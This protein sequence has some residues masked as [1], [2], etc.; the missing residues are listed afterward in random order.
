MPQLTHQTALFEAPFWAFRA[1]GAVACTVALPSRSPSAFPQML[2][3]DAGMVCWEEACSGRL[4]SKG[5]LCWLTGP[6]ARRGGGLTGK[7]LPGFAPPG[8]P[9]CRS[10]CGFVSTPVAKQTEG[11]NSFTSK[12][13]FFGCT[14]K[15]SEKGRVGG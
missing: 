4:D 6:P 7:R 10:P 8:P 5:A 11:L 12:S 1:L 14:V 3:W 13:V 15:G 9:L 2:S